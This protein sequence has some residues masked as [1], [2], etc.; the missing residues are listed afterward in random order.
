LLEGGEIPFEFVRKNF[1]ERRLGTEDGAAK[2]G[3]ERK[4]NCSAHFL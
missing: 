4:N 3:G 2:E 1:Y